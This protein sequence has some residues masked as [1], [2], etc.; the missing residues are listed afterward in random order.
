MLQVKL[1]PFYFAVDFSI[2]VLS[3]RSWPFQQGPQFCL[4][5]EVSMANTCICKIMRVSLTYSLY[6]VKVDSQ[7]FITSSTVVAN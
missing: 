7:P 3:T 4:P 5:E 1:L 6:R 2:Q